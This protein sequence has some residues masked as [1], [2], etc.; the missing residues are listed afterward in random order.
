MGNCSGRRLR[1]SSTKR[2]VIARMKG[3]L[4][5]RTPWTTTIEFEW[6]RTSGIQTGRHIDDDTDD[7]RRCISDVGRDGR[8]PRTGARQCSVAEP[9]HGWRAATWRVRRQSWSFVNRVEA[10]VLALKEHVYLVERR[11]T[12][13]VPLPTLAQE[14]V[15]LA[16][17]QRRSV[18]YQRLGG[19]RR[20]FRV[21]SGCIIIRGIAAVVPTFAVI[22]DV[23]VARRREGCFT[24]KSKYFPHR[25]AER[26][27]ITFCWES[28]L[29]EMETSVNIGLNY[30]DK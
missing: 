5:H 13:F 12:V 18:E 25:D 20:Q 14:V 17:T 10:T 26:P 28:T 24:A 15:D 29:R 21:V 3:G 16:G 11:A 4:G 7:L 27:H 6:G 30:E 1:Y 22:Y 9:W 19:L 2:L 8:W 23:I